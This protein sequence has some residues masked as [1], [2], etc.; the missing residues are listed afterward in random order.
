MLRPEKKL[1]SDGNVPT[2]PFLGLQ[3]RENAIPDEGT[4][5]TTGKQARSAFQ[6]CIS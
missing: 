1:V 3:M 4:I 5:D 6:I 2:T